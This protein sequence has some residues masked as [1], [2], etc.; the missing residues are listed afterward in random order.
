MQ[1]QKG[2]KD[3]KENLS[4]Q[5]GSKKVYNLVDGKYLCAEPPLSK[6]ISTEDLM[7]YHANNGLL[8]LP[9][10][11]SHSQSIERGVKLVTEASHSYYGFDNRHRSIMAKITRRKMRPILVCIQNLLLPNIRF[12]SVT[13]LNR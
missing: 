12:N 10:L 9:D 4:H 6:D 5:L 2:N 8:M 11:P 7:L 13:E 1:N 3:G